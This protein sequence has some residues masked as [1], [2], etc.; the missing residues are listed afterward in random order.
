[1]T[2]Q[3]LVKAIRSKQPAEVERAVTFLYRYKG[4]VTSFVRSDTQRDL[5]LFDQAFCDDLFQEVIVA[6]LENVW[7]GMFTLQDNVDVKTYLWKISRL[8]YFRFRE[9]ELRRL[10]RDS[11]YFVL[12][13]DNPPEADAAI[14]DREQER[15]FK[16]AMSR[17]DKDGQEFIRMYHYEKRTHREIGEILGISEVAAKQRYYRYRLQLAELLKAY[18][19]P[20]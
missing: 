10:Q 2:D 14:I 7:R 1:M 8:R 19:L 3:E 4:Y 15:V 17:L 13:D 5:L 11:H 9:S 16:W 18:E 12:T 6:F 20:G